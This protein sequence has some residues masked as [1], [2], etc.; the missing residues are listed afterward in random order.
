MDFSGYAIV[1]DLDGTFLHHGSI[2]PKNIEAVKAFTANGGIFTIATGRIK[3]T[4]A[5]A[6]P[7]IEC[8]INAPAVLCN[9][10]YLYDYAQQKTMG[11]VFIER[12]DAEAL[13]AFIK[14]ECPSVCWRVSTPHGM[15]ACSMEGYIARDMAAYGNEAFEIEPNLDAW[16]L[17]DW[18][19]LVFRADW[20]EK[21][22]IKAL[23][24]Q[25]FA[26]HRLMAVSSGNHFLE[27][28]YRDCHKG[29]GLSALRF[30]IDLSG[31][32]VIACGDFEND[33]EMLQAADIGIC[34]ANALPHVKA[35]ADHVLCDSGEGLMS[36]VI[37]AIVRNDLKK[38]VE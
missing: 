6:V 37:D 5:E 32:T 30:A 12:K 19:K 29:V 7:Q 16:P 11:E 36:A 3:E 18:Y 26:G 13:L 27:V 38:R 25:H 9:G 24:E 1:T 20:E 14:T 22:K 21:L 34:P 23:F 2:V 10:S 4:I 8:L 28:F 31:R 15:R 33:I 35:V 17:D